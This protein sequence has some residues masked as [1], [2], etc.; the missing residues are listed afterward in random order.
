MVTV[1]KQPK[2]DLLIFYKTPSNTAIL[3]TAL[4]LKLDLFHLSISYTRESWQKWDSNT[5]N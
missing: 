2:E 3:R 1:P 4:L 5:S